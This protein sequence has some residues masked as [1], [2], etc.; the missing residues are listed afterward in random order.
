MTDPS[1]HSDAR[2]VVESILRKIPGFRGYLEKEYR[3]ESDHLARMW[4]ADRLDACKAGVGRYQR[5]LLDARKIDYL[6][7]C[8]RVRTRLDTLAS[9]VRGAMRG[10]SGLFGFVRVDEDLLDQVYDL[11][12]DLVDKAE[13]LLKAVDELL[14]PEK[15]PGVSIPEFLKRVEEL[16]CQFDRRSELLQG[17]GPSK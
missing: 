5:N 12:L 15:D 13:G 14:V 16:H 1:K 7:D 11:D 10:Y 6:D 3:R 8:V 17:L 9:R 2:G 4:L